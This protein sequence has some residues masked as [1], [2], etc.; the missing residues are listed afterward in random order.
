[1]FF[2][3]LFI[4]QRVFSYPDFEYKHIIDVIYCKNHNCYFALKGDFTLVVSLFIVNF[5][6]KKF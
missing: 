2:K 5:I 1:M 6:L 4:A 3:N